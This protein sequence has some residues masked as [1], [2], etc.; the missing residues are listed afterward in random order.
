ME[1]LQEA[2]AMLDLL[3]QPAFCVQNGTITYVNQ[4]AARLLLQPGMEI[5][6]LL[7]NGRELYAEEHS[8]CLYVTIS[9]FGCEFGASVTH[10]DSA[11]IFALDQ[12][13]TEVSNALAL[14][15]RELRS[16]L[17]NAIAASGK[18]EPGESL[19]HLNRS[20]YQLLRIIGNMSDMMDGS[21][22]HQMEYQNADALFREIWEKA[23]ALTQSTGVTLSY[24]GLTEDTA[25]AADSQL[26]ERAM[27]NMISN[28]LKFTPAGGTI[29]CSLTRRDQYLYLQ[30]SDTGTGIP[31]EIL[32]TVFRRH[33]R[34]PA[35][36]DGRYG[37]GLGMHLIRKAAARHAGAVL[38]D[39][40][41]GTGTRV[42]MTM[43]IRPMSPSMRQHP[44][45]IDYAGELD[46]ALIELSDCLDASQY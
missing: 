1:L 20:L 36:E 33:L 43:A 31:E 3:T 38:I 22:V 45:R 32:G 42:T 29:K 9:V 12:T 40:P 44:F 11:D 19:S 10:T 25:F 35:I 18:L 4:S 13:D 46:H 14:A 34:Q 15:A 27:L 30:V 41:E 5:D 24:S 2:I 28:A 39:H 26:L 37:I 23:S 8:G 6:D 16:P 17:A 21:P 7:V